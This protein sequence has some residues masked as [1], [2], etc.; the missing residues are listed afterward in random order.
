MRKIFVSFVIASSIA[1]TGCASIVSGTNQ[2]ITVE[3]VPY[4]GACT[5]NR[6]GNTIANLPTT[7]MTVTVERSAFPM[8]VRCTRDGFEPGSVAVE[9]ELNGW[10]F[11]N[12]FFGGPIGVI[13]DS[14]TGA[15]RKY[16]E[17]VRVYLN[18]K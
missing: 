6:N 1:L 10:I 11:G 8:A 5:I 7:P 2:P 12:I 13:V 17:T 18:E 15:G 4:G 14:V 3:S 9:S 16:A